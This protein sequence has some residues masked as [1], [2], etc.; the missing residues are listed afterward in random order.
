MD[1]STIYSHVSSRYTATALSTPHPHANTV[2]EAFGYSADDLTSTP[3]EANLGLSCGNPLAL[4][5]LKP[6]ETVVDL[7]CG[8]GF[9]VFLVARKVGEKGRVIGVDMNE[10]CLSTLLRF[11]GA[12]LIRV[13]LGHAEPRPHLS[14]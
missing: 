7:G 9:D 11:M 12:W 13:T 14:N 6:G 8:A 2:A 4:A 5:S 3:S 1:S 10:V